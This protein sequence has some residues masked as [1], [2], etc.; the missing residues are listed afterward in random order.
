MAAR[1]VPKAAAFGISLELVAQ[2]GLAM[3][4]GECSAPSRTSDQEEL[5]SFV[6][7]AMRE[8]AEGDFP[9]LSTALLVNSTAS[10][11]KVRRSR[12]G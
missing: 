3:A 10:L 4:D 1:L 9:P 8:V 7:D 6:V 11:G 2:L 5:F 12:F